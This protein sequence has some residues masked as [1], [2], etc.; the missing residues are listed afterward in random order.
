VLPN[1]QV[2][3]READEAAALGARFL[4]EGFDGD[5]RSI[6]LATYGEDLQDL[7]VSDAFACVLSAL[8]ESY[9][10]GTNQLEPYD[11]WY[12]S[13]ERRGRDPFVPPVSAPDG[14]VMMRAA[15]LK[16]VRREQETR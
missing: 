5:W 16:Q 1:K 15:W 3:Q 4:D 13:D 2:T 7:F 11:Q 8:Y 12:R 6:L 10:A 14:D 9:T